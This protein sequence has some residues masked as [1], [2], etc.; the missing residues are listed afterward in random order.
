[1]RSAIIIRPLRTHPEYQAA[2]DLQKAAWGFA[3][4]DLVPHSE[5]VA[6][7]HN[8]GIVLGAFDDGRLVAFVF[9]LVGRRDGRFHQYSRMLAVD[10]ERQGQGLGA[11]LKME[12]RRVAIERGYTWMEWTFDPLEARNAGLNLRRLG[13]RVRTCFRDLYGPRSS[14]FDLG[15]PTD[16]FLAEWDLAEDL[17]LTG[18]ARRAAHRDA[19]RAFEVVRGTLPEPGPLSIDPAAR[20][21]LIPVPSEFQ[22]IR[23]ASLE[24]SLK[25]RLAVREAAETAL[26][27]GLAAVDFLPELPGA[28]GFGAHVMAREA[29]L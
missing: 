21:I 20:A 19:G 4:R 18:E 15:V 11:A 10:P 6:A 26:A 24:T 22:P 27:A 8:D 16:R 1:M 12:Q 2:V 9:S 7:V 3:D 25:W 29:E 13:A 28:P 5:L 14:R 23:E 17:A